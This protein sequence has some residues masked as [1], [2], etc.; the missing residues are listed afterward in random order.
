MEQHPHDAL[1]V[2][3]VGL[4]VCNKRVLGEKLLNETVGVINFLACKCNVRIPKLQIWTWIAH[5]KG[6]D[7]TVVYENTVS[8]DTRILGV[9]I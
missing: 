6:F 4:K 8:D 2:K 1:K 5:T 9:A 7:I 3:E